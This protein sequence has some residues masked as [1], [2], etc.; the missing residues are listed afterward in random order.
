ME[1]TLSNTVTANTY[2]Q[3]AIPILVIAIHSAIVYAWL[4]KPS[5]AARAASEL[6]VQVT[7]LAN[8][9]QAYTMALCIA[10]TRIGI[11]I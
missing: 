11:A 3:I 6:S 10:I 4:N 9:A 1:R 5:D 7:V 8:T 2:D